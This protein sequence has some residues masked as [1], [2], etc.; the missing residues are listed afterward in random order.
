MDMTLK[1]AS[2]DFSHNV[3]VVSNV[4]TRFYDRFNQ[5]KSTEDLNKGIELCQKAIEMTP[6]DHPRRPGELSALFGVQLNWEK[7]YSFLQTAVELLPAISPRSLQHT[8]KQ[9]VLAEFAG[10]ASTA[11]ATAINARKEAH[12]A[13][14]LLELGRGVIAGLLLETRTDISDL[15]QQYPELGKEFTS[16]RDELDLPASKVDQRLKADQR[17]KEAIQLI[18][19]KP[20]FESFLLPP[21]AG[22][23]MA[24][25]DPSP[26]IVIHLSHYRCDAFIIEKNRMRALE[27]PNLR[28]E[29][30]NKRAELLKL[31]QLSQV[32]SYGITL[33]FEWLWDVVARPCLE[34]LGFKQSPLGDNLPHV[35]WIPTGPLS[36]LPLHAAG[37][38]VDGGTETVLDRVMF[39]YSSS[40]KALIYGRQ[41]R[42]HKSATP[43]HEHALLV[44]MQETSGQSTLSFAGDEVAMLDKL[45]P[46][47]HLEPVKPPPRKED[48][49]KHLRTCKI[50]HFAGH[51]KSDP[52]EPSQSY[53][54]LEDWEKD[55]LTVANLR[56]QTLQENAPFLGYLSACSTGA[57]EAE[58]LT[59]EGIH[60]IS[61][62]QLAGF[63]HVVGT[64]WGVSDKYCVDVARVLYETIEKEGMTDQAIYRE[65]HLAVKKLRDK[66]RLASSVGIG[67]ATAVHHDSTEAAKMDENKVEIMQGSDL[68]GPTK[69]ENVQY[70][71]KEQDIVSVT[72]K[73]IDGQPVC[74]KEVEVGNDNRSNDANTSYTRTERK[75]EGDEEETRKTKVA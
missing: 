24:A 48:V 58:G 37:K 69:E 73:Q 30:V 16:L 72:P 5:T 61:A 29:E 13:L 33:T 14:E 57:N 41:H 18:R 44:S 64:L 22:Q 12:H 50:F 53:L 55:P 17:F 1:A 65:Y 2:T 4:A 46:S 49:L 35:W 32:S 36:Y 47:L 38:Y 26:I 9:N 28:L 62:C 21:T 3:E 54:L 10:L 66:S 7:S 71:T 40:V 45:C 42:V 68:S 27:L 67:R 52:M 60:L 25:A 59:D 39:S 51:G 43:S 11:A 75:T 63:R 19:A 6:F 23:M 15:T 20:E 74:K 8:D 56:D 31:D 34:A 70:M